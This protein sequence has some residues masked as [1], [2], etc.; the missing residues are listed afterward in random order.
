[1]DII[2]AVAGVALAPVFPLPPSPRTNYSALFK[3]CET[4][5]HTNE[6]MEDDDA[7]AAA[8]DHTCSER[9]CTTVHN[10]YSHN[11]RGPHS[12]QCIG[13]IVKTAAVGCKAIRRR[14]IEAGYVGQ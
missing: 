6:C 14:R 12:P 4:G 9:S 2:I 8:L 11:I 10:N 1:M 3:G 13:G 5:A 7:A